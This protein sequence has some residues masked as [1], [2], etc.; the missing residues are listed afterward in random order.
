MV[1]RGGLEPPTSRLS[2]VR[3]NHLSYRPIAGSAIRRSPRIGNSQKQAKRA[4]KTEAPAGLADPVTLS[5]ATLQ[6]QR[7][8]IRKR[9]EDGATA[10]CVYW[11][12]LP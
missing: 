9:N 10:A 2:G 3:S 5:P 6:G 8:R 7:G 11:L 1:G 12:C 4:R